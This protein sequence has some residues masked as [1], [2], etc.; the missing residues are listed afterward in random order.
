MKGAAL[1]NLRFLGTSNTKDR[2]K[3]SRNDGDTWKMFLGRAA[4]TL[5]II[6]RDSTIF[7]MLT[8]ISLTKTKRCL[9]MP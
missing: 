7:R 9:G 3:Q 2:S 1:L 6:Q 8:S 4:A 5:R